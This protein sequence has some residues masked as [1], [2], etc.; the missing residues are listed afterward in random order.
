MARAHARACAVS[1]MPGKRRRNSTAAANSPPRSKAVRIA[2]ASASETTNIAGAWGRGAWTASRWTTRPDSWA[3][4]GCFGGTNRRLCATC[5]GPALRRQAQT[6]CLLRASNVAQRHD[7][8]DSRQCVAGDWS[9]VLHC[10]RLANCRLFGL[11]A[12]GADPR[13]GDQGCGVSVQETLLG[14]SHSDFAFGAGFELADAF[15]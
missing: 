1:V 10:L 7:T 15:G 12:R 8:A 4:A 5:C 3:Q 6:I 9:R 11:A 13:L 14:E 2:T